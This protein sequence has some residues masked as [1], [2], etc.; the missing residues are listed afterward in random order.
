MSWRQRQRVE[1]GEVNLSTLSYVS[2]LEVTTMFVGLL[3][4]LVCMYVL[5]WVVMGVKSIKC[6]KF[7]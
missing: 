7:V 1:R 6:L 2:I 3:Y 5:I 4:V